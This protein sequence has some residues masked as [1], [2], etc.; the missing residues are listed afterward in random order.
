M[1]YVSLEI[2]NIPSQAEELVREAGVRI[3]F[4]FPVM[5][6]KVHALLSYAARDSDS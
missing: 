1:A 2:E 3:V 6:F 5:Y 4:S